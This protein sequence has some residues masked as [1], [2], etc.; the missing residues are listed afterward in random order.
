MGCGASRD[1]HTVV[2]NIEYVE[3]SKAWDRAWQTVPAKK[4]SKVKDK[5][6]V[7]KRS[8]WKTVRIFVSSTF[9]D[10]HQER[11]VLIK[12]VCGVVVH[13]ICV[14]DLMNK[15][16]FICSMKMKKNNTEQRFISDCISRICK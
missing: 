12:K 9:K 7:V 6:L 1:S 15:T 4:G 16:N 5:N 8:S 2:S 14:Q 11:E 13:I 10:F 3:V